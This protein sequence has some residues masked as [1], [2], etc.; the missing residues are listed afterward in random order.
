MLNDFKESCETD[1]MEARRCILSVLDRLRRS[2]LSPERAGDVELVLAEAINNIVEH[3]YEAPGKGQIWLRV[4]MAADH[5]VIRLR[6]DGRPLPAN[7][8][9]TARLIQ[10]S[11][12]HGILPEG[13]F[14]WFL[15]QSLTSAV[16]YD[17]DEGCNLLSLFFR[18][19]AKDL[20]PP[21]ESGPL[22]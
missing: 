22:P 10:P 4:M 14:G 11:K 16:R 1:Q 15:I 13:G 9:P 18:I 6:D 17:R 7:R 3:A 8:I 12:K 21:S 2:G 20:V 19:Q 5:L